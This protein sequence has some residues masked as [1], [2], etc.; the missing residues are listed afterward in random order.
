MVDLN[1]NYIYFYDAG[2]LIPRC[3]VQIVGVFVC[4]IRV[5]P[6][7]L[8]HVVDFIQGLVE[9]VTLQTRRMGVD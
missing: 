7:G 1:K 2:V 8:F 9:S 4:I 5:G 6:F 3:K